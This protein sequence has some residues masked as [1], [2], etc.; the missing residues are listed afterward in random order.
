[1]MKEFW[2]SW[3]NLVVLLLNL[4][5]V[6]LAVSMRAEMQSFVRE[7]LKGYVSKSQFDD[8][9]TRHSEWSASKMLDIEHRLESIGALLNEARDHR[10]RI[11]RKVDDEM[12]LR[13]RNNP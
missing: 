7:E 1:M 10:N 6:G 5:L 11:E 3:G 4:F 9:I 2:K 8:Y 13:L 12:I